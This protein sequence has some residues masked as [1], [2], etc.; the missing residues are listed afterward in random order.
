[1]MSDADRRENERAEKVRHYKEQE[2]KEKDELNLSK[3]AGF[4]KEQMT[5][6]ANEASLE[7]TLNQKK[8]KSQ[9][10]RSMDTNFARK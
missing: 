1:M 7:S 9:G 10:S 6:A 5:R 3:P 4:I 8:F 2:A